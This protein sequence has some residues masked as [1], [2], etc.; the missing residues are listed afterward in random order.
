MCVWLIKRY[1]GLFASFKPRII[2]FFSDSLS[3]PT[4]CHQ[5]VLVVEVS[6]LCSFF[7]LLLKQ[8]CY[9]PIPCCVFMSPLQKL[10][11]GKLFFFNWMTYHSGNKSC[12]F[13]PL[14]Q[15]C[16]FILSIMIESLIWSG[17]TGKEMPVTAKTSVFD[18]HYSDLRCCCFNLA[19]IFVL[20]MATV[21]FMEMYLL[22]NCELG[23]I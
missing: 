8:A 7:P 20:S 3:S 10:T 17:H 18:L 5:N 11:M 12:V 2:A 15:Q 23:P 19:V 22:W 13:F 14:R 16:L 4:C 9:F 1:R 21:V 6:Q